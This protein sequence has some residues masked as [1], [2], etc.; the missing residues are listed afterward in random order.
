MQDVEIKV[1][2]KRPVALVLGL[3]GVALLAALIALAARGCTARTA[4]SENA[5]PEDPHAGQVLVHDGAGEVWITPAEGVAIS[6]L[7]PEDFTA[8]ETTHWPVYTGEA[9]TALRGLDVADFQQ[10]I[11]WSAVKDAGIDFVIIRCGYRGYEK[12]AMFPDSRFDEYMKGALAAGLQVGVYYFSQATTPDEA[13]QEALHALTLCQG[14]DFTLPIYWDW[15]RLTGRDARANAVDLS[16]LT[17]MAVAWCCTIERNG[18]TAGIYFNRQLGYY[19]YDWTR[20]ADRAKWVAE[21]GAYP[22]FYYETDVWQYSFGEDV[23]GIGIIT[24]MNLMF[25]PRENTE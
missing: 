4:E 2:M 8:D 12:G 19:A 21:P 14:Y 5:Q 17:D 9:Y 7:H 22:T 24:D 18:R 25:L 1:R 3:V 20:L 11:D 15:E 16:E 10:D 6:A 23:P 13:A